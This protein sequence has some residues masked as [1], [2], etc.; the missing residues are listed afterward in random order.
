MRYNGRVGIVRTVQSAKGKAEANWKARIYLPTQK[1]GEV[2]RHSELSA[3][4]KVAP[5]NSAPKEY[6]GGGA[7]NASR[8]PEPTITAQ[9]H[10]AHTTVTAAAGST[11]QGALHQA[12]YDFKEHGFTIPGEAH[13]LVVARMNSYGV[14]SAPT[15]H[16]GSPAAVPGLPPAGHSAGGFGGSTGAGVGGHSS[17]G[18]GSSSGGGSSHS[19]WRK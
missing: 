16:N 4:S 8:M 14:V 2:M 5:L 15:G 7:E 17:G 3:T 11:T 12:S 6:R 10:D 13:P 19:G 18:G 1:T 9:F